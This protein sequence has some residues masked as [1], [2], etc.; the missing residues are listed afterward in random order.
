MDNAI[1]YGIAGQHAIL[2]CVMVLSTY[3]F[4]TEKR[5][6]L[7]ALEEMQLHQNGT[8]NTRARG[9]HGKAYA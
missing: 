4:Y 8:R 5:R 1:A 2:D 9:V 3:K 7:Q 6:G